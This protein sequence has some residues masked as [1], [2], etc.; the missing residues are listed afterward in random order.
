MELK[1][2][3]I[4]IFLALAAAGIT[5][6]KA[7]PET[8]NGT[9][10]RFDEAWGY[11]IAGSEPSWT[12]SI[13]LTDACHFSATLDSRGKLVGIPKSAGLRGFP[14]RKHL[15]V[16]EVTNHALTHFV[17]RPELPFRGTLLSDIVTASAG[18]D[19]VQVD[20]ECVLQDDAE[21]YL[22][23]LA[24][25]KEAIAPKTLSVA[26]PARTKHSAGPFDYARLAEIADRLLVMA[27][28][29]HWSGSG[30]GPIAS[31]AWCAK[32]AEYARATI[33]QERLV[34]GLPLYGRAWV[35][36]NPAKAY[37]FPTLAALLK[38]KELAP[39]RVHGE[40]PFVQYEETVKVTAYYE[41]AASISG[42]LNL[43]RTSG[44]RNVGFWRIGLEDPEVWNSFSVP[45]PRYAPQ[46]SN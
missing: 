7:A 19:G 28:D 18:Y 32:V 33:G 46:R 43:Y 29:E 23:F 20:F 45:L 5:E 41:D 8:V 22:S 44:V 2:K 3:S 24:A 21:N 15:V 17:L 35:E 4:F 37:R 36:K 27:Y 12:T 11:V 16:A 10:P 14:G 42:K 13:P 39:A 1:C 25:L 40:I 30:P 9:V 6:P 34:M 38:E 31:I 26:I